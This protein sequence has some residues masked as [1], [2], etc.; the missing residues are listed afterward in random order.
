MPLT[1]H[2]REVA[3]VAVERWVDGRAGY[4]YFSSGAD[5]GCFDDVVPYLL[6]YPK[7]IRHS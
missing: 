3:A 7:K 6:R 4:N 5:P 1:L 2:E